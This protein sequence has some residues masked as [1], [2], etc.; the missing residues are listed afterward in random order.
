MH[1]HSRFSHWQYDQAF[2]V[3]ALAIYA[4]VS[5][6]THCCG[7]QLPMM[8]QVLDLSQQALLTWPGALKP[9]RSLPRLL[10]LT[11]TLRVTTWHLPCSTWAHTLATLTTLTH[12]DLSGCDMASCD[13]GLQDNWEHPAGSG[14]VL[15]SP[16]HTAGDAAACAGPGD[17]PAGQYK[18]TSPAVQYKAT[19]PAVQY[20]ATSP[21]V[22]YKATSPAGQYK[23]TSPAGQYKATSPAQQGAQTG[24]RRVQLVPAPL[25][26]LSGLLRL[27]SL[28]L[29]YWNVSPSS[30]GQQ[31]HDTRSNM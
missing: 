24:C 10:S 21:A 13:M 22:Q 6:H 5:Q 9:L 19:S 29:S 14:S 7:H 28:N 26:L 15:C 8:L 4:A 25:Q 20:K 12:L 31:W 27:Q 3:A 23:A 16:G 2:L 18:A 30:T 1:L 11:L 17:L